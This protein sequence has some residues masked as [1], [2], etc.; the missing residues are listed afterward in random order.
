M[1]SLNKYFAIF[2]PIVVLFGIYI[3]AGILLALVIILINIMNSVHFNWGSFING[4]ASLGMLLFD[5]RYFTIDITH[6]FMKLFIVLITVGSSFI[7]FLWFKKENSKYI[8]SKI[9]SI[10]SVNKICTLM[11]LSLGYQFFAIGI[12]NLVMPH[13][14][15]VLSHNNPMNHYID[16]NQIVVI[17]YMVLIFPV[18]EELIF[19]GVILAKASKVLPFIG[20]NIIQALLF[21]LLH[22]NIVQGIYTFIAGLLLGYIAY[23]FKTIFASIILNCFLNLNI[24]ILVLKLFKS[25]LNYIISSAIGLL[26]LIILLRILER[27]K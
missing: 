4:N 15:I 3:G 20:A 11:F 18:L 27:S 16:G 12:T 19:R 13:F 8:D 14:D 21:G 25:P 6:G 1:K 17:I 7:F 5:D 9:S 24:C 22:M 23:K 2:L 26:T 10:I